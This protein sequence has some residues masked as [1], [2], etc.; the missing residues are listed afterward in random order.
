MKLE[1][2]AHLDLSAA[3]GLVHLGGRLFA[4]AD[5]GLELLATD[6][7]GANPAR[8]P[9]GEGPRIATIPKDQKPDFEALLVTA[10]TLLA[11]GSGSSAARRLAIR[12]SPEGHA[13][14]TIDLRPLYAALDLRIHELNI[15]GAVVSGDEVILAQRGN[16]ARRENALVRLDRARFEQDLE[17]GV[18]TEA[19]LREIVPVSLGALGGVALS[20]TDLCL[21]PGGELLF[22]AAAE[23]TDNPNDDGLVA[24]SVI[25][26]L[27]A[28][29]R[30][31]DDRLVVAQ[32]VKLEGVCWLE[33]GEL[34]LVADPDDPSARAPLFRLR[35]PS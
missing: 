13:R 7:A 26:A 32:G 17:A 25:G 33:Q 8:L 2:L 18:L 34:R 30:V 4:V 21:G 1:L 16:G 24:G 11:L 23:D 9:L 15:E 3:S 6:L 14:R 28:R 19:A 5:D 35:W 12:V 29:G 20:L 27:D 22:T 31:D 10:G